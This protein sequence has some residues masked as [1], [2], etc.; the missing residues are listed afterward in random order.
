VSCNLGNLTSWNPLGLSRSVGG[1][2]Y[3]RLKH[4][5]R[6]CTDDNYE[7]KHVAKFI[8]EYII[9]C[10]LTEAIFGVS[11][12]RLSKSDWEAYNKCDTHGATWSLRYFGDTAVS[13]TTNSGRLQLKCD[14]TR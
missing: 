4:G 2:L 1:L 9:S 14:G 10:V 6:N 13:A 12:F 3:L 7:S 11:K 5:S 8:I